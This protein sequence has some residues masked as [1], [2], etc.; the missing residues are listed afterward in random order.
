MSMLTKIA[1]GL[2]QMSSTLASAYEVYMSSTWKRCEC[3]DGAFV[4]VDKEYTTEHM[5]TY[6]FNLAADH[7]EASNKIKEELEVAYQE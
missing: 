4:W 3:E 2:L 5:G 7:D 6:L 1:T